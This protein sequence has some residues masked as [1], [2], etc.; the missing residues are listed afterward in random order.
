MF[1]FFNSIRAAATETPD[2]GTFADAVVHMPRIE[3][4]GS[5]SQLERGRKAYLRDYGAER[6]V[7]PSAIGY[8]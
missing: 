2:T 6:Q 5:N 3:L 7:R 8:V 4:T 1:A